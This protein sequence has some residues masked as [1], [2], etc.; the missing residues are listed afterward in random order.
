MSGEDSFCSHLSNEV[1]VFPDLS[2]TLNN[3]RHEKGLEVAVEGSL[4]ACFFLIFFFFF[5]AF[6]EDLFEF[7][8]V[9][10]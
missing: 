7:G 5:L 3:L 10:S 8:F 9:C 6:C 2:S 1:D 4:F